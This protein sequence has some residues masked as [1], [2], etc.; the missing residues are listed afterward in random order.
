MNK[1]EVVLLQGYKVIQGYDMWAMVS[2][3]DSRTTR[4]YKPR[5]AMV[6]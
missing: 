2:E 4:K 1:T 5:R 6:N 3:Q